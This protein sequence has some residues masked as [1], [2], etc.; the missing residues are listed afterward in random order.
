MILIQNQEIILRITMNL[1]SIRTF[2]KINN[3]K[4]AFI[5]KMTD[6]TKLKMDSGLLF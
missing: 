5:F 3:I 4:N 6:I 1:L 2:I